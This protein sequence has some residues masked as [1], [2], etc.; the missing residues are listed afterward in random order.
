VAYAIFFKVEYVTKVFDLTIPD[1]AFALIFQLYNLLS[2][3]KAD[4]DGLHQPEV[5]LSEAKNSVAQ[6][7][8]ATLSKLLKRKRG[9]AGTTTHRSRD[10]PEAQDSFGNQSVQRELT[11]AGYTLTQPR[12]EELTLLTPVSRD[13]RRCTRL[14]V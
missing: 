1:D 11:S 6:K 10:P 5:R 13:S 12:F 7:R 4:N 8:Y 2:A 9:E 14:L 3:A